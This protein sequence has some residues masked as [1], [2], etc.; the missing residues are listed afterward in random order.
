MAEPTTEELL[1]RAAL[2]LDRAKVRLVQDPRDP[3]DWYDRAGELL[4]EVRQLEKEVS[5]G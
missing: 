1:H 4:Y 5:G 2:A 3:G